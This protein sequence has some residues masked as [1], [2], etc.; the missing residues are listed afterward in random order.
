MTR[1]H[2]EPTAKTTDLLAFS[3]AISLAM[4]SLI[5]CNSVQYR[6]ESLPP[7]FRQAA[8]KHGDQMDLSKIARPGLSEAI[9][10]PSDLLEVTIASG[11]ADEKIRPVTVRVSDSGTIDI[12]Y[13]G[14]V[15]VAGKEVFDASETI[16]NL[17]I[18]R[19]VYVNPHVTVE[20]NAK[21]VNRITVLGAVKDPGVHELPRGGCDLISA[22]AASG[23]LTDE[24]DTI[25]EIVRDPTRFKSADTMQSSPPENTNAD[26]PNND[27]QLA[28]YQSLPRNPAS[29]VNPHRQLPQSKT[30][31]IRIDLS[32]GQFVGNADY[33]L[34][35]RD[36]VRVIHREKE[37]IYVSGLVTRAGQFEIPP[38]QDIHLLDAIALSGGLSSPVAD[39]VIIIRRLENHSKPITIQASLKKAKKNGLENIR[40][41]TGD[42]ISVEQTPETV[43]VDI[44]TNLIRFS[45]G[46]AGRATLF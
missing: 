8:T 30:P 39:K 35:D 26:N 1:K 24:A 3:L 4:G 32:E 19:G 28:A 6:A 41:A 2:A 43:V 16:S 34:N 36:V 21:S 9:I 40:L 5:G 25:V 42:T 27:I 45:V 37:M 15:P 12:P 46:V 22:L 10:A 14:T 17:S 38:K 29:T 11:Y 33:R 31:T 7:E 13:V 23:G 20:I 18:E 44:F